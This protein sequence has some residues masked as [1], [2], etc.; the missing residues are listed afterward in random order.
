MAPISI[1]APS[2]TNTV[3]V[4]LV[5]TTFR[6]KNGPLD[7]FMSPKIKG[8]HGLT[9]GAFAFLI[10]H[11]DAEGG[12]KRRFLFDLGPPKSWKEDLPE[13]LVKRVSKWED[14]GAVITVEK[15][16]SEILEENGVELSSIEGLIWSHAHWDHIGKPSLFPPTTDLI[17]GP[18]ITEKFAPG[19]PENSAAPFKSTEWHGR[20]VTEL[21]FEDSTIIIG[22]MRAIDFFN[23]GS[24]YI[25]DAPGHAFGHLNALAR[26]TSGK[27]SG[28]RDTFI[29]MGADSFHLGSQIR[30]N[31]HIPLPDSIYL[32][33]MIPCPCPGELFE[34]IHPS[35]LSEE[36]NGGDPKTTPFHVIPREG[37]V[38]VDVDDA[39]DVIRKIQAF[40]ADEDILVISA[41]E[42]NYFDVLECFPGTANEWKKDGWKGRMRWRFLEEFKDGVEES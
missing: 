42:W 32:P 12:S 22:E 8:Q 40:D 33:S 6:I 35:S 14:N 36:S 17:I 1:D 21:N 37:S 5:D 16:V 9:A 39:R 20:K 3:T 4:Q 29:Y 15:Y 41:H 34:R 23:D 26:T 10:T 30:P 11:T 2:S 18:S 19:Y 28:G 24:F 13:P 25:L 27:V 31:E 7:S 38:A